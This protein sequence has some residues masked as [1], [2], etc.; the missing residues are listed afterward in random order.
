[1]ISNYILLVY[2]II[3]QIIYYPNLFIAASYLL[4]RL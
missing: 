3:R 2:I 4:V 1:M